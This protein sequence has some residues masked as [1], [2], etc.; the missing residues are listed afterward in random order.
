M[1]DLLLLLLLLL[2]YSPHGR[3]P[4]F[5]VEVFA[6]FEPFDLDD[7]VGIEGALNRNEEG[8]LKGSGSR[9][10]FLL[11]P[12]VVSSWSVWSALQRVGCLEKVAVVGHSRLTM[13]RVTCPVTMI[14]SLSLGGAL[15]PL[16]TGDERSINTAAGA[17]SVVSTRTASET[18]GS[19]A[20]MLFAPPESVAFRLCTR[21][22][23]SGERW[24]TN[25]PTTRTRGG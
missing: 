5:H 18:S 4:L 22:K 6:R 25:R 16:N 17:A 3:A 20:A 9:D 15:P 11:P 7:R 14:R 12:A 2:L 8:D 1:D 23:A 13:G 19:K 21:V 24:K 10:R